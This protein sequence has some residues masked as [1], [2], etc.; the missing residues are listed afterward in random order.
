MKLIVT[1]FSIPG[2]LTKANHEMQNEERLTHKFNVFERVTKPSVLSQTDENF[3]WH[4]FTSEFLR[5]K[6]PCEDVRMVVHYVTAK[7]FHEKCSEISTGITTIR[8][9]DDDGISPFLLERLNDYSEGI[10]SFPKGRQFK[11]EDG[12]I[13]FSDTPTIQP[14]VS[15]GMARINADIYECGNHALVHKKYKVVYDDLEDAYYQCCSEFC[16]SNRTSFY[17]NY[18][19]RKQQRENSQFNL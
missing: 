5:N 14:N 13:V 15:A 16:W 10:I 2:L 18:A 4:I 12:K 17:A 9:D 6:I 11:V 7:E 3:Q 19:E 1:R 8:L